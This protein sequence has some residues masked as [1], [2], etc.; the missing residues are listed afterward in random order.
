M[1]TDVVILETRHQKKTLDLHIMGSVTKFQPASFLPS[2]DVITTWN[3]FVKVCAT[4]YVAFPE[5]IPTY[6]GSVFALHEWK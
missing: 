1:E 4:I 2:G 3:K 6:Q 5:T